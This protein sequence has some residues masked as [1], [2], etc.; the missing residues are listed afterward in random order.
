MYCSCDPARG[1]N[2]GDDQPVPGVIVLGFVDRVGRCIRFPRFGYAVGSKGGWS[3]RGYGR[4]VSLTGGWVRVPPRPGS[5]KNTVVFV[6]ELRRTVS[7][8]SELRGSRC[9]HWIGIPF[10]MGREYDPVFVGCC[11]SRGRA[12]HRFKTFTGSGGAES[13]ISKRGRRMY[14][15]K[16]APERSRRGVLRGE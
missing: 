11:Q 3:C 9:R 2:R 14:L 15:G 10:R 13:G 1:W 12:R 8:T 4:T 5:C 7:H 16:T 6:E